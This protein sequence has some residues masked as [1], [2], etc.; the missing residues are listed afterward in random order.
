MWTNE[1]Q[2]T[3]FNSSAAAWGPQQQFRPPVTSWNVGWEQSTSHSCLESTRPALHPRVFWPVFVLR[4]AGLQLSPEL[5]DTTVTL[6]VSGKKGEDVQGLQVP[7]GGPGWGG[8]AVVCFHWD[9]YFWKS[10]QVQEPPK[11]LLSRATYIAF[12]VWVLAS[13]HDW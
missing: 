7:K 5:T 9:D 8:Y 11:R 6:E 12:K 3:G 2:V 4:Y 13:A 10:S 1:I